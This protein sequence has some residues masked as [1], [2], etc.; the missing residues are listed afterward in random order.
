MNFITKNQR[1]TSTFICFP[2]NCFDL[3]EQLKTF[4]FK[5]CHTQSCHVIQVLS[6]IVLKFSLVYFDS[7][8]SFQD[9]YLFDYIECLSLNCK[10]QCISGKI[11]LV[12]QIFVSFILILCFKKD[13]NF[14]DHSFESC[15]VNRFLKFIHSSIYF[16]PLNTK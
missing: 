11:C 1:L 6:Y 14:F 7:L 4:T 12:Q 8:I 5:S 13:L 9:M 2:N 15:V 16:H 10:I 3:I